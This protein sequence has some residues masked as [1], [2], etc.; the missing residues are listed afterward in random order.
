MSVWKSPIFYFGIVL[1]FVVGFALVAPYVINWTIYRDNLEAYGRKLTG[2]DVAISGPISVSLFPWPHLKAEDVSLADPV[3]F[4]GPAM[5]NANSITMELALASLFSG[6]I[7]VETIAVDRPVIN[8]ARLPDGRANWIF[9]PDQAL[10]Q[11]RLLDQVK[12]DR[13][14]ITGGIVHLEDTDHHFSTTFT[15]VN[16]VLSAGDIAGPWRVKGTASEN[17][18]PLDL[19]LTSS[20]WKAGEPFR[21]GVRIAALDGS[22][23][24]V[25]FDG[26]QQLDELKGKIRLEPVITANGKASLEGSFKPLQM[27]AD[28]TA[29][30][31][32]IAF[33]KIRIVSADVKDTG[34]LIEGQASVALQ[35]GV[36]INV[37][38]TAPRLDLD[39]LAG[40]QSLRVWRAGGLMAVINGAMKAFPDKFD[41]S[42]AFAIDSLSA[43]GETIENV[44]LKAS[45]AQ[46]SIRLQDFTANL[47]GRSRMKFTGIIFAGVDAAE[48]G[49]SL[50]LESNDT[51][52]LVGWLWPERKA[53]IAKYWSG[54]RGRLKSQSDITWSGKRFGFQNLKYE[55][56]GELGAADLAV[57]LGA[58]PAIDVRLDT[59]TLNLDNYVGAKKF[60]IE[61]FY[62][63]VR[64]DPGLGKRVNV[65]VGRLFL[66]SVEA[67]NV[68]INYASGLSGFEI[69]TFDI[70]SIEG[71]HVK[72][73]GLVLQGPDGFSGDI[74]LSMTA[75]NPRG[76]LRLLGSS[77]TAT[78]AG[79]TSV[80]GQTDIQGTVTV[81]P[82]GPEPLVSLNLSGVSGPLHLSTSGEIRNISKGLD[83][84][85]GFSSEISAANSSDL[86]RLISLQ[87]KLTLISP[88]KVNVTG[89]GSREAGYNTVLHGELLGGAVHY[90]GQYKPGLNLPEMQGRISIN[91]AD[92]RGFVEAAGF[93]DNNAGGGA[94]EISALVDTKAGSLHMTQI[95]GVISAHK[96]SGN[97]SLSQAGTVDADLAT[98]Q[99]DLQTVMI[100]LFMPWRG[101]TPA[102][103]ET[104]ATPTAFPVSGDVWLRP[105][106]LHTVLT[107]DLQE[108]VIGLAF[109]SSGRSLSVVARA[110]DNAPFNFDIGLKANNST[111][112]VTA[113]GRSTVDLSRFIKLQ[114]GDVVANGN[115]SID[116]SVTGEGRNPLAILSS[117]TGRATYA[118]RNANL[119]RVSPQHF[120]SLLPDIKGAGELRRAFDALVQPPGQ[121]LSGTAKTVSIAKGVANFEPIEEKTVEATTLVQPSFDLAAKTV[122]A[123]ITITARTDADL[124]AMRVTYAGSTN[125]LIQR[126]DTTALSAKLGFALIAKDVAELDRV[127]KEQSKLVADGE[128][129]R[130]ADAEKFAAFQAQR[131]ELRLR[132]RELRIH[133]GQR[134]VDA[135]ERKAA[136]D[137]IL[138]DVIPLA[139]AEIARL[140][141][142]LLHKP[143]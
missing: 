20:Q 4:D 27:Q 75:E 16:M 141:R 52:Q 64:N 67:S 69:K 98:D 15:A 10:R 61:D 94:F 115:M 103:D 116:G 102:S 133:A 2:R 72:G 128:T 117:L 37:N 14:N 31:Q 137:R 58:F 13:I 65:K 106:H 41:L 45:A 40:S 51:R 122:R 8:I 43:A 42:A 107:E 130:E 96:I 63:V 28:V 82:G 68:A 81:K 83:A 66:N 60:S 54:N 112:V 87:P 7:R 21:F 26:Q 127:Q 132:Q 1:L 135:A 50:A 17:G 104:F 108:S 86:L 55:L 129:Q 97:I 92:G 76:V 101:A 19:T 24:S 38:L 113:S 56:D 78:D 36:K 11:S 136:L 123:D 53:Q 22:L 142:Q 126:S 73:Q 105:S 57:Q 140:K 109:N 134:L 48:L 33:D 3:G 59:E 39:S 77:F 125:D 124:P 118:L 74:K 90:E 18:I 9:T 89:S 71:A 100:G 25:V 111:F 23:P 84:T 95:S 35:N 32:N 120:F 143:I 44:K 30:F 138:A 119:T 12:L 139:K 110:P 114:N 131:G 62:G 29:T 79:W 5:L 70:G 121:Q 99:V 91:A 6:E 85:L 34:T 46:N 93:P 80:L 49:G 47:P 88:G